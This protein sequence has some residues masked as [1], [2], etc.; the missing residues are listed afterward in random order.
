MG[1]KEEKTPIKRKYKGETRKPMIIRNRSRG[2]KLLIKYNVDGIFIGESFVHLTSY[3]GVVV[4]HRYQLDIT[5]GDMSL[6]N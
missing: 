5:H 3:L 1:S 4:V 6:Y 2:I